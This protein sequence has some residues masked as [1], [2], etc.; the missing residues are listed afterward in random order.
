MFYIISR[1][2]SKNAFVPSGCKSIKYFPKKIFFGVKGVYGICLEKKVFLFS[3]CFVNYR[4]SPS[5]A[6]RSCSSA[7]C[8]TARGVPTF[9]RMCPLPSGP[10]ISPSLSASLALSFEVKPCTVEPYDKGCLR[11][12]GFDVGNITIEKLFDKEYI[13]FDVG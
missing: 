11:P 9:S 8:K 13:L 6:E 3:T 10:N 7:F 1:Y 5:T 4:L 12:D 2:K